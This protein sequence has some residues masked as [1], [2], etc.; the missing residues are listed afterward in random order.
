[1][2]IFRSLPFALWRVFFVLL[3]STSTAAADVYSRAT[4]IGNAKGLDAIGCKGGFPDWK[5]ECFQM[6]FRL[7]A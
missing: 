5:G 2:T 7:L 1:M 4:K 3:F 6:P